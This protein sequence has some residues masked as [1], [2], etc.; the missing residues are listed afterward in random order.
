MSLGLNDIIVETR[1]PLEVQQSHFSD[2]F[3]LVV[4]IT[5]DME[6]GMRGT[7]AEDICIAKRT[8]SA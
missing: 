3:A 4:E 5:K 7:R 2:S 6:R 1:V 8:T